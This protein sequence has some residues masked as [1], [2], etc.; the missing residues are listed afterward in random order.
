M[1]LYLSSSPCIDGAARAIL[2]PANGFLAQLAG[3]LPENPRCVFVASSPEDHRA[4]CEF[5]SHMFSAFAEAGIPFC[6][7][8][9]LDDMSRDFAAELIW[10]S[11]LVILAGGHVPTQNTFFQEIGLGTLLADYPGVVLGISAGSMN[12]AEEVYVQPEEPGEGIDPNFVRFRPG[13][14]LTKI[15]I[16][17]HYQKVKDT[18]LDGLRLFEDITYADSANR[19]LYLLPDGS[20]LRIHEGETVLHGRA[21]RLRNGILELL[22]LEDESVFLPKI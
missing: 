22:T 19:T 3:D 14:G 21:Y 13:L 2:N 9:V 12:A 18:V 20:Y 5:G 4:T 6:Q 10:D 17:P 11:D 1:I 15:R 8:C 7:Y 16:C